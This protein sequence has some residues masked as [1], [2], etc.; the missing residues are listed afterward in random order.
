MDTS[1][2][3]QCSVGGDWLGNYAMALLS[4]VEF[5][6][7]YN[8]PSFCCPICSF[9]LLW[10]CLLYMPEKMLEILEKLAWWESRM[11]QWSTPSSFWYSLLIVQTRRQTTNP[12]PVRKEAGWA[13]PDLS[14]YWESSP[15][16]S[17]RGCALHRVQLTDMGFYRQGSTA[18]GR[19][20]PLH[21]PT[22]SSQ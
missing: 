16:L 20:A 6:V 10:V 5:S 2:I 18:K 1:K 4:T 8:H 7:P 22:A 3:E 9:S 13:F 14:A 11:R 15:A 17:S 19:L 21:T 12:S